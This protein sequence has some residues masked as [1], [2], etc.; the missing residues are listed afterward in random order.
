MVRPDAVII[1]V[2][3]ISKGLYPHR[4]QLLGL[5]YPNTALLYPN[6]DP[7]LP[8]RR[9]QLEASVI[10]GEHKDPHRPSSP[11]STPSYRSISPDLVVESDQDLDWSP[12]QIRPPLNT[13]SA[14]PSD[15]ARAFVD[16]ILRMACALDLKVA[17]PEEE[18]ASDQLEKRV[19]S[20]MINRPAIPYMPSL[21]KILKRSWEGNITTTATWLY[22]ITLTTVHNR[23]CHEYS[24]FISSFL[25]TG[26]SL[27]L[28]NCTRVTRIGK[29]KLIY[30]H[31]RKP[32]E[33]NAE[34]LENS[35]PAE[36]SSSSGRIQNWNGSPIQTQYRKTKHNSSTR[37]D[38]ATNEVTL[39][40][41]PGMD[42]FRDM[43]GDHIG[44]KKPLNIHIGGFAVSDSALSTV[45]TSRLIKDPRLARREQILG[46][47][48]GEGASCE[49]SHSKKD[50][51]YNLEMEI[52]A[53]L[54]MP[55]IVPEESFLPNSKHALIQGQYVEKTTW[56]GSTSE[57]C[58]SP[59]LLNSEQGLGNRNKEI[60]ASL[61]TYTSPALETCLNHHSFKS[62]GS[63]SKHSVRLIGDNIRGSEMLSSQLNPY[64]IAD[65]MWL[66]QDF[67]PSNK[68]HE[69]I[70]EPP[71]SDDDKYIC[72]RNPYG[73]TSNK[74][75]ME[76]R[77]VSSQLHD[78]DEDKDNDN[79]DDNYTS[80]IHYSDDL[81]TKCVAN[82]C[83]SSEGEHSAE[84][85]S[86]EDSALQ[87]SFCENTNLSEN[88]LREVCT[89]EK[90]ICE[91]YSD[92][93]STE[94][95]EQNELK[96]VTQSEKSYTAEVNKKT[97]H[98]YS[99]SENSKPAI[100]EKK[101]YV[102]NKL[103]ENSVKESISNIDCTGFL[104]E[105]SEMLSKTF[106]CK[107]NIPQICEQVL[108]VKCEDVQ[109]FKVTSETE[110]VLEGY[111]K[112]LSVP[113]KS[114]DDENRIGEGGEYHY[115]EMRM[116]WDNLF[117]KPNLNTN[118]PGNP[119]VDENG[120]AYLDEENS[121][122]EKKETD[123]FNTFVCPDLEITVTSLFQSKLKKEMGKCASKYPGRKKGIKWSRDKTMEKYTDDQ[124]NS[125]LYH[126]NKECSSETFSSLSKRQF[127]KIVQS[128]RHIKSIL[129]TLNREALLCKNNCLSRRIGGALFHLRKAR[130][131]VQC[132]KMGAKTRK[133]KLNDSS[134]LNK[135][136]YNG[137]FVT[138]GCL[139]DMPCGSDSVSNVTVTE[140]E[141][142]SNKSTLNTGTANTSLNNEHI[143]NDEHSSVKFTSRNV[144]KDQVTTLL[145]DTKQ[146]LTS[147]DNRCTSPSTANHLNPP[148]VGE[149]LVVSH[150]EERKSEGIS[151]RKMDIVRFATTVHT[152]L[153]SFVEADVFKPG[154]TARFS[155]IFLELENDFSNENGVMEIL[156]AKENI[157]TTISTEIYSVPS[158]FLHVA[159]ERHDAN[160]CQVQLTPQMYDA[161]LLLL[162]TSSNNSSNKTSEKNS[163]KIIE[164]VTGQKQ[165][166]DS[167]SKNI[168]LKPD[169][170]CPNT[171][172][173]KAGQELYAAEYRKC[174]KSVQTTNSM[175]QPENNAEVASC[176]S[177]VPSSVSLADN[178]LSLSS[179]SY[180]LQAHEGR[181]TAFL[182]NEEDFS[183]IK[184]GVINNIVMKPLIKTGLDQKNT[185]NIT[186]VTLCK[187]STCS[188]TSSDSRTRL[189]SSLL[190][191]NC[192]EQDF[193]AITAISPSASAYYDMSTKTKQNITSSMTGL[194]KNTFSDEPSNNNTDLSSDFKSTQIGIE[195]KSLDFKIKLSE[196]LRKADETSSLQ[197]LHKQITFCK[198][199]LPI[200]VEAFQKQ[201]GCS[202]E[203]VLV[204]KEILRSAGRNLQ[205]CHKLNPCA[206]ES[207]V[208]LQI[209]M[210]TTEFI[211][212][213]KRLIE[214]EPT[215]RSL[216]WYDNSLC[217]E[218]FG[219]E[220]G[221][222][223]QSNFYPAFQRRL[224]YSPLNELQSYH[225]H[226][227]DVFEN[228]R[229]ENNSY[230]IF[231]KSRREIE[232]CEAAMKSN[233]NS[234]DFFLSVPY[235]CG[236][237]YGDT[238][239]DLEDTRK[240]T[241]HL[242]NLYKK[243]PGITLSAEKEEHI[244]FIMEI[245]ATKVNFIRTCEE[246][247]IKTSLFG[248]EH[249]FFDAAKSLLLGEKEKSI[250]G[251]LK[252]G[253]MLN[254]VALPKFYEIYEHM[255]EHITKKSAQQ[256]CIREKTDG[257]QKANCC[258]TNSLILPHDIFSISVIL[259]EAQSANIERLQQLIYN[260]T[261]HMEMLKKYF[262]MLQEEDDSVLIT[263]ENVLGFFKS[264]GINTV[265]LKPEAVEVYTEMAMIYETVVY[266]KNLIARKVNKPRF[267]SLLF[268]ESSLAP[269][270][271]RCQEKMS[272]FA[273]RKDNILESIESSISE[274][275]EE[276]NV[277]Y[278]C[279]EN[280]NCLYAL[281]L[282]TRELAELSETRNLLKTSKS[283]ISMCVDLIPYTIC[284]NYGSTVSELDC[285]YNQ[286][287]SLLEKLTLGERKDLGKMAH[288]MKIMKTI[289][290]MKF[291]CSEQRKSPLLLVIHQMIK[292][293]RKACQL[294]RQDMKT[295]V[296]D[297][298]GHNTKENC[299]HSQ[300]QY[301]RPVNVT[302]EGSLC[303][304]E[305]KNDFSQSKKKKVGL[306]STS[307]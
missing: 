96:A 11:D 284:L 82:N 25:F 19:Q 110:D 277:I 24:A 208:E 297:S 283:P 124:K 70:I 98:I 80:E 30:E 122:V 229:W 150:L 39:Q 173:E 120:K 271:F 42:V 236:A 256:L 131:R 291:V 95:F 45:T 185:T 147:E 127:K 22:S 226:L 165:E 274:L 275:Q 132:L 140:V 257:Q 58:V 238:L 214:G 56:K 296:D 121:G 188:Q 220:A 60:L 154:D 300:A 227:V 89:E 190:I 285:N 38:L 5:L 2:I 176:S 269:E 125:K 136:L 258:I 86:I 59:P 118:I 234:S 34:D 26:R 237:N 67:Q 253:Q 108:Q 91:R 13:Q 298:E 41:T 117:G 254:K 126:T 260:T 180:A 183:N 178:N 139:S 36:V 31:F 152:S 222:Q 278:D 32:I 199:I 97:E 205:P 187:E 219:G 245:I 198:D 66:P 103:K 206:I 90:Y 143:M 242:I 218:L 240:K 93:M 106:F 111:K 304:S 156:P 270:L 12:T 44:N 305:E 146:S 61:N 43:R 144:M 116:D 137:T 64:K 99:A 65:N 8:V 153:E 221:S 167:H 290:H 4:L 166:I 100:G 57:E 163:E 282:L 211:E 72:R 233:Y 9:L 210:E 301:K 128:E 35:S 248:L 171:L 73:V 231:L 197:L 138:S 262:Q 7:H 134:K 115:L 225:K 241:M 169:N 170:S 294:K 224:K 53:S 195:L 68:E 243:F 168:F 27:P 213:K 179:P 50:L 54:G 3:P 76:S 74:D 40:Q 1:P 145:A 141:R 289:E 149:E 105:D 189:G 55:Y 265:I 29:S 177:F 235:V 184:Q 303:S 209:V 113:Q 17:E 63:E 255:I 215:F 102:V 230:Y 148:V 16:Q 20:R 15:D 261:E 79:N 114:C 21:A 161:G 249:I 109:D 194:N 77:E 62:K 200:F 244:W 207:L 181:K 112:C 250:S 71:F 69:Y 130:R 295:S 83:T 212:N 287:S 268:F 81:D 307:L 158:A 263:K 288:I 175:K 164:S 49:N 104:N 135:I 129:N 292:N 88:I 252:D 192:S 28:E 203:H 52:F 299:Q 279:S 239:E 162:N 160:V 18:E 276:I 84:F 246:V 247:N 119:S 78:G 46:E 216:L 6:I 196:I 37:W 223:Q 202:F 267:R 94:N 159:E 193:E 155:P 293:W 107:E 85:Y 281:H 123:S 217:S 92:E 151:D 259:D 157:A 186:Q 75:K 33:S 273:Y 174:T 191:R 201:Q 10:R 133:K 172:S 266:L 14:S 87:P 232:E 204:S 264:G 280:L 251:N 306:F 51:E 23:F 302:L 228:T 182:K 48:N 101:E 286:F 272:S 142:V 47:Q